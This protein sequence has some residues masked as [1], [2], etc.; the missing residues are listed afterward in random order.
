MPDPD[1]SHD[2]DP[3]LVRRMC[4]RR[5]GVGADG[6][7]RVVSE[8]GD[9]WFMDYRNADGSVAEMCG[10]GIRVFARYLADTRLVDPARPLVMATR[11]GTKTVTFEVDGDISVDMGTG[12]AGNPVEIRVAGRTWSATSVDMGNPHAVALIG[13]GFAAADNRPMR[14]RTESTCMPA[15]LAELDL[16]AHRSMTRR[17]SRTASTSSSCPAGPTRSRCGS[18]SEAWGRRTRAVPAPVRSHSPS[19]VVRLDPRR[20]AHDDRVEVPGSRYGRRRR[21]ASSERPRRADGSRLHPAADWRIVSAP[22]PPRGPASAA[23]TP[24]EADGVRRDATQTTHS[25][26]PDEGVVGEQLEEHRADHRDADRA[27]ELLHG[28]EHARRRTHLLRHRRR[29]G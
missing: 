27:A 2:L 9:A 8:P 23:G 5:A 4:D 26:A 24:P 6:I 16:R 18:M 14:D 28:V 10:N 20:R 13:D 29:P 21:A 22:P 25:V 3:D 19:A 15:N 1:R 7:L 12:T 11:G 17:A